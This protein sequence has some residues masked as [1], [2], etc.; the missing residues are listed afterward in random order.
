MAIV[1]IGLPAPPLASR[2]TISGSGVRG[3]AE[4]VGAAV[5]AGAVGPGRPELVAAWGL[6]AARRA[7][8]MSRAVRFIS[9]DATLR[10][11]LAFCDLRDRDMGPR[12]HRGAPEGPH[13]PGG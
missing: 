8:G 2:T 4:G 10:L 12:P 6:Q 11:G 13:W 3:A 1:S 7:R 9:P 5:A